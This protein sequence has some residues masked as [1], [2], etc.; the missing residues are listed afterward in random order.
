VTDEAGNVIRGGRF[1]GAI[2]LRPDVLF[3]DNIDMALFQ[4]TIAKTNRIA[5]PTWFL[6]WNTGFND[7]MAFGSVEAMLTYGTRGK[8]IHAYSQTKKP[9]AEGYLRDYLCSKNFEVHFTRTR[10]A[11]VR[12]HGIHSPDSEGQLQWLNNMNE[13]TWKDPNYLVTTK[14]ITFRGC[15][16]RVWKI[17]GIDA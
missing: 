9:H 6:Y 11:R 2:Y 13:K 16:R 4:H 14:K 5:V 12:L 8:Y 17:F 1:V 3:F 7:R 15:P 10:F